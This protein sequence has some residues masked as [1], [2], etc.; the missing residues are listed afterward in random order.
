[1]YK[2]K[3]IQVAL[4]EHLEQK[5]QFVVSPKRCKIINNNKIKKICLWLLMY[6]IDND[7]D[8]ILSIIEDNKTINIFLY[9]FLFF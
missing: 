8:V 5:T 7:D 2:K 1:M 4:T 3:R 6:L 9:S